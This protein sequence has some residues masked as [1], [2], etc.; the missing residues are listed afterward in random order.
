MPR[1]SA[2]WRKPEHTWQ[3]HDAHEA[4]IRRMYRDPLNWQNPVDGLP[5]VTTNVI[6]WCLEDPACVAI[7]DIYRI[8]V[9]ALAERHPA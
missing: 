1:F 4:R 6:R 5:A 2:R 3:E 9:L 7:G 8:V